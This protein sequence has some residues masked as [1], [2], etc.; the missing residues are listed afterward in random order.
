MGIYNVERRVDTVNISI[1]IAVAER[2]AELLWQVVDQT[3]SD[4]TD[5][6]ERLADEAEVRF[7]SPLYTATAH[8]GYIT[9]KNCDA[10]DYEKKYLECYGDLGECEW[11]GGTTGRHYLSCK[12]WAHNKDKS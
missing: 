4:L 3:G 8:E 5:L 7:P 2:L 11:C 10:G 1:D 9:V 12:V 6:R